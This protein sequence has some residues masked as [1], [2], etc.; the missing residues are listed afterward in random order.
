MPPGV[1]HRVRPAR[2]TTVH[3]FVQLGDLSGLQKKL[4]ENPSL[5]NERN[6]I[7]VQT[8][9]HVAS[10]YNNVGIVKFLLNWNG[11]DK[12]ELEAKNMY[13][14]TPLH[15][16]AKNGCSEAAE[17][18]I[19]HGAIIE[20][21]ANNGMT[22]LHLA[23]WHA[24][25][26]EDPSTVGTLLKHNADCSL[27]DDEGV[28]PLNL[29]SKASNGGKLQQLLQR[30]AEEQR[31]RKA[32]EI[33]KD[34]TAK[35]AE[36][37]TAMATIVGLEEIK[38]QLHRW[39]KGMLMDER[40]RSLGLKIAPRRPPHMAFLGSPGT[41]KTMIARL[42]GKLLHMVGF[43][44]T[45]RVTEVQRTDLV[46]EFLEQAEGG[47]LFVDEA[48]RLIPMQKSDD[49]DYGL[50]AL[51]EIMSVMDTGKI[52]VIFAG[53]EEPMKRVITSNEGF[54]RR[55]TKFFHFKDF[56][57]SELSQILHLKM[58]D[59]EVGS[60]LYGFR[61]HPSCTNEAVTQLIE[62]ETTEQQRKE[63][64]GGLIEPM[65]I[66]ARENLDHRLGFDCIDTD[67]LLTITMEDLRAG[68]QL[69]RR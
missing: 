54:Y 55:V 3:G 15:M 36:F 37:E 38:S 43:L 2:P 30:H 1:D 32:L 34:A 47:I 40:R 28:T 69:L 53:Y 22:P 18:L 66:N 65:L 68:L 60:S 49:K 33:C 64:N 21:R 12:V 23:V 6:E 9:L 11:P 29:L 31:R 35:M 17:L 5:L 58:V 14:E 25:H 4:A 13:G 57:T 39:A 8:P 7:M 20:A 26:A 24:L 44:P 42:L 61:L 48:Y 46:G 52:V 59:T 51:E 56:S 16:A 67:D 27:V 19:Q 63:M 50:E 45:D 41:G 62:T 10:G